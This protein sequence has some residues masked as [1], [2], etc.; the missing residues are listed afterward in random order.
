MTVEM[1]ENS[2]IETIAEMA[3]LWRRIFV[4]T[5]ISEKYF[6]SEKKLDFPCY[7]S[8]HIQPDIKEHRRPILPF[9]ADK[10]ELRPLKSRDTEY[11]RR[12]IAIKV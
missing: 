6:R 2:K 7:L 4:E 9:C 8:P 3:I 5:V 11:S 12:G 10:P 1:G